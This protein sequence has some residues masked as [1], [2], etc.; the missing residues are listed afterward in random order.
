MQ[1]DLLQLLPRQAVVEPH[2]DMR[3][4]LLRPAERGEH[5]DGDGAAGR[6]FQARAVPDG[7]EAMLEQ[8][9]PQVADHLVLRGLVHRLLG[10][11]GAAHLEPDLLAGLE[12]LVL[13]ER[14]IG[15][16]LSPSAQRP[17]NSGRRRSALALMP[18]LKSAVLRSQ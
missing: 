1:E 12:E 4:Q 14:E 2:A 9:L 10:D 18:S 5:R 6:A 3:L 16:S 11:G 15:H 13:I 17:W 8:I 7:A